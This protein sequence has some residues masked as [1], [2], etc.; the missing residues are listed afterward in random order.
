L[1][2]REYSS[3]KRTTTKP[4]SLK[5]KRPKGLW[6]KII[7]RH[8]AETYSFVEDWLV[9]VDV[10]DG[11]LNDTHVVQR[12]FAIIGGADGDE[13]LLLPRRFVAIED[14]K[15]SPATCQLYLQMQ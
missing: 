13:R 5:Y 8:S 3:L 9:V 1:R 2:N 15:Q 4:P 7:Q 11:D 6:R 10:H 12:G 14:L